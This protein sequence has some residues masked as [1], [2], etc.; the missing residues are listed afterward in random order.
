MSSTKVTMTDLLTQPGCE[1]NH[2]KNGK[3]HNKVCQQ[4]A[5]PGAAQGG[6]AFDGASIALVPI[7]DVA[8]L[9]HGPIACAGNSWGG[10][11]SLSS[12]DT[13]YK[14]GF[15]TDLSE[16][17]IIFGGEKKL[18]K[19]I[20][21]VQE[22]YSPA[23]VF[24]YSTCVTALIGDDLEAVCKAA[25]EALGL[26]VVP[27]QSPGFVGSKNLGNRLAGEALLEHVIGTAEP[28]TTTPYDINLIGE[29]NI[30]GELWGV[31][32]LFEK[33]GIR[34]LSK[35]TGDARYQEVAYAHRAKLNV[36]ICSK[37]L[38]NLA[39]KM[40]ERYGIPYIEESF[41]GVADMN[42]CLR[43]IAAKLGDEAMQARVEAVIAEETEKLNQQLAPYRDRL[44]GKRVVLYTGGVKSW[45]IIS[46]AQDLGIKVVATSSKKSTEEDK[47]RIKTLLGQDGIMLAKGGAAEL[48]KVIEQTN[49]DM[50]IAGGRNQYTALKARIPFLHIN[51]ERHNPYSGY[52]GLLEMAKELDETLHSPVWAEVRRE[53]PWGK[54]LNSECLVLNSET[55]N[56]KLKTQN[57]S[58]SP[59]KIIARRKAVAVNPLKQSQPLGAALAF[60]GIQGAMPLF[61]GSQGCTAF[62]K[63][64]LVN[65][66]QE[67]IPLATTAMSEVSTVLGGDDN[68]HS[69]LLTVIKNSQPELVGLFT[70]GLT[71]TRGDDMQG[72]L[73]DFHAANPD[74]TVP[75]V[76]ASTPDYKGSL[77]DGFAAAVESLVQTMPEA[78]EVN[79]K[80]ITLL[81]SAAFG[82]GDV[83]ELKE[84]VEAFGLSAIAL[85]DLSTSLDGHLEDADFATT[86]TGGITVAELKAVGRSALTL[87]LGGS[88]AGAAKILTDRF[89]TPAVTFTQLT[90]LGAVDEFLHTLSQ[91]SGQPVPAK[92]LRQRRQVQDAMLDTHF[93]FGR[94]KVAIALEPDLLHNIAWWLHTTGAEIQAAVTAAPSPLLKD[95]PIEQVYIGDFED[96]EAMAA[97]ADLWITNSKAR[98]IAR[99]LGIPLYLHGFP[100]LEHLGNGH[101]CTVGYRGTLDLLFAIGNILLEADEERTHELVHQWREGSG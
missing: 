68:V 90:G 94:K 70:T 83:A 17:D 25:G 7:T 53:A 4:Q 36:M 23:A 1:H 82:P 13:L 80:Q 28:E 8:H 27:V 39:H 6:C 38:I 100:L 58:N 93:F 60:L 32:P 88:M 41:Y 34:V 3:G 81:A 54:V 85:P 96:L 98:P 51:Q 18:Y 77:E 33:V 45:S 72:I 22:R 21:D 78:G 97:T 84:M 79:P 74:V 76:F 101:R 91:I 48:L 35:I 11:G 31:L 89:N 57:S 66:F 10:R 62:A 86:A 47:A 26:P 29:Y 2:K 95:L 9:V 43:A 30:A 16:N 52:G 24:V 87:A 5:K 65:H 61:H 12:G 64:M 92:Y 44:L 14:M 42:H 50:L 99:R 20:Q 59:T 75:I 19:A 73:R 63:V 69:G 49:A 55:Q 40:Q 15:T 67:A 71:E 46:A 37:A 56:S